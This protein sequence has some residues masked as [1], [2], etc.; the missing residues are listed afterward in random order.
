LTDAR[1]PA[2]L[3]E[4]QRHPKF[5]GV[6]H[7]VHDEPDVNWLLRADVVGGLRELARRALGAGDREAAR[8]LALRAR[9]L[10]PDAPW[11][12]R[13][14]F[15]LETRAGRWEA[16][17]R[18]LGEARAQQAFG[19]A[20]ARHYR[21]V[22]LYEL[23]RAAAKAG[24]GRRALALA[25][26]AET[27]CPDLAALAAHHARLLYEGGREQAA[28]RVLER[29]WRAAPH[30]DLS[31]LY[32]AIFAAEAPLLRVKRF[33]RL[34]AQNPGAR[35]S[36]IALA[37]AELAAELWGEARRALERALAEPLPP[38]P[39]RALAPPSLSTAVSAAAR[40]AASSVSMPAGT[41]IA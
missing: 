37:E 3:D 25:A 21:G 31:S 2:V 11:V 7:L 22:L 14:L 16:A 17:E 38:R 27:F 23:S 41:G 10:R 12:T 33:E 30:P 9:A 19:P 34:A 36:H 5:N 1:L 13:S 20:R 24:D 6:R 35:E 29:A 39:D 32:G 18:I 15:E 8:R 4:L 26:S 28:A 40:N